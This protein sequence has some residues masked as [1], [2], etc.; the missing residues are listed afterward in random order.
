MNLNSECLQKLF[1]V[2][3]MELSRSGFRWLEGDPQPRR[4]GLHFSEP[5]AHRHRF[6][7]THSMGASPCPHL[8]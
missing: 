1:K 8:H 7:F 5:L 3:S 6:P 2:L 4:L